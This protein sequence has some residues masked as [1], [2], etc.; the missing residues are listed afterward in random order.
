MKI[1][2]SHQMKD[3]HLIEKINELI[4]NEIELLI[5]EHTVDL[6]NTISNKIENLIKSCDVGLV[7]LT[8]NGIVSPFVNQEI[9]YLTSL[10]KPFLQLVEAGKESEIKGFN[11]GKDYIKYNPEYPDE[12]L[13]KI[14]E[15]LSKQW[16]HIKKARLAKRQKEIER[17]ED[18][19]MLVGIGIVAGLFVLAMNSD[20]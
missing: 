17:Q 11:Y 15:L 13:E 9:G 16:E 8:A 18:K 6:N 4:P 2:V 3:V 14:K 20:N 1:F 7:L 10:K 19:K 5:A 12:A